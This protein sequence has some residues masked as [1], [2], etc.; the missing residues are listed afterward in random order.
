MKS[1]CGLRV[2]KRFLEQYPQLSSI[3]TI[4]MADNSANDESIQ[5]LIISKEGCLKTTDRE[6]NAVDR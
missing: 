6:Q 5:S 3:F 1:N 4:K 2:L